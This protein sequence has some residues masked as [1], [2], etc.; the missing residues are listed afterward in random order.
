MI[1]S[2]FFLKSTD[3]AVEPPAARPSNVRQALDQ[4]CDSA[5]DVFWPKNNSVLPGK[6][7]RIWMDLIDR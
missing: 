6:T 1:F 4:A 2:Q 7:E 5:G 3:S